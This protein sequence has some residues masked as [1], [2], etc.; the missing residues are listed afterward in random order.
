MTWPLLDFD[1]VLTVGDPAPPLAAIVRGFG[2]A[3]ACGC[4]PMPIRR[5]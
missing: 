3:R 5:A 4:G 2:A 1:G